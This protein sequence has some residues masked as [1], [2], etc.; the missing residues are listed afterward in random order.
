[1]SERSEFDVL[2]GCAGI[3][4]SVSWDGDRVGE[5]GSEPNMSSWSSEVVVMGWGD[6]DMVGWDTTPGTSRSIA[7]ILDVEM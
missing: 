7:C 3:L 5:F 6:G 2:S 1:M 4:I